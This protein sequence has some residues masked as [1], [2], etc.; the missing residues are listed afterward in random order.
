MQGAGSLLVSSLLPLLA[1]LTLLFLREGVHHQ[2]L[3]VGWIPLLLEI[4]LH[5]VR[6]QHCFFERLH[7]WNVDMVLVLLVAL[8]L[9]PSQV[10]TD[11]LDLLNA[12]LTRAI[13]R[14]LGHEREGLGEREIR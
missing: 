13:C 10:V 12:L 8:Q 2:E 5:L 1:F 7:H 3:A 14:I 6:H 4:S 9:R 11:G